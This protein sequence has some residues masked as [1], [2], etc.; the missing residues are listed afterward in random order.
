VS[1]CAVKLPDPQI[2]AIGHDGEGAAALGACR[3]FE[4][5]VNAVVAIIDVSMRGSANHIDASDNMDAEPA[6]SILGWCRF[7]FRFKKISCR[8]INMHEALGLSE[9]LV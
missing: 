6:R 7:I 2:S 9:S 5:L 8:A 4:N 3:P 1:V